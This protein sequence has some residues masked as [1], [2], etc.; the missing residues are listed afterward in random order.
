[1]FRACGTASVSG[2]LA[3]P[4]AA[5]A[6]KPEKTIGEDVYTR[7]GI[8]PFINLTT[9][10]TINGGTLTRPEVKQAMDQASYQ[11]VNID[12]VMDKVGERLAKLL[13]CESAIV[14]SGCA[15][16]LTHATSACVVGTDP[17]KLQQLPKMDGLKDEVIMPKQSRNV[18]DHAIRAVGVRIVEVGSIED[19]HAALGRRTAMIAVNAS[20]EEKGIR[21][22][23]LAKAAR[24]AGVP[25]LVDAA[26]HYPGQP[27]AWLS[28]GADLVACSG[29]KILQGPQCAG[30][31]MGRKDL[32]QA[33]WIN[34]APHHAF[35][36]MAKVGKEEI[37]GMLAAVEVW[38]ATRDLQA[39]HRTFRSWYSYITAKIT[40]VPGVRTSELA[41]D[42]PNP[43]PVLSIEWDPNKIGLT[44]GELGQLLM[45]GE[46]R[47]ASHAAGEGH[48]FIIRPA[49]M[50]PGDYKLAADR[51]YQLFSTA[52]KPKTRATEA[53]GAQ[54]AG[55]W[56]VEVK[57][58]VGAS[59][60]TLFLETNG[61]R[62]RGS[63]LGWKLKGDLT[64]SIEGGRVLIRS[65]LPYEGTTLTYAF[66]GQVSGD[67]MSGD[68]SLGEY[69]RAQ[70]TARRHT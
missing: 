38:A 44:A 3:G 5:R 69:G 67:T 47:I 57:Y 45:D 34:S 7:V 29:G 20:E 22:E 26:A 6:A 19:F 48:S 37:M 55:R 33:A 28:R 11:S 25:I 2:L 64:G 36:R 12:E 53:P 46:P 21:L 54:I 41:P 16:A 17:E 52:P 43:F 65:K 14:T 60:H 61:N 27:N 49:A 24:P 4:P 18:Y 8:R 35:G 63:H 39:E 50:K 62:V 51:L 30:L 59:R 15:G 56:D 42:G 66:R 70:W 32:V 9:S 40:K 31:L 58:L 1:M 13:Q 23:E 68:V 10:W